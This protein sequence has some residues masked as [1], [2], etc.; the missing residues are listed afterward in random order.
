MLHNFGDILFKFVE[1]YLKD[2]EPMLKDLRQA[3]LLQLDSLEQYGPAM[4][5]HLKPQE[6]LKL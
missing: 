4:G 6:P 1:E 3:L 2:D 5:I